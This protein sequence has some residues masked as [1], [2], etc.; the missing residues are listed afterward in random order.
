VCAPHVG[1]GWAFWPT[2]QYA[3][4]LHDLARL[5]REELLLDLL[6]DDLNPL[7]QL[8]KLLLLNVIQLLQLVQLLRHDL[9][10]L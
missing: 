7:L 4:V 6:R 10:R 5:G 8:L 9:E 2:L 3:T 1:R